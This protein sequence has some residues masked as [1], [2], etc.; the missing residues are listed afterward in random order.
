MMIYDIADLG[1]DDDEVGSRQDHSSRNA[2]TKV[3]TSSFQA[4][5]VDV[6]VGKVGRQ[7]RQRSSFRGSGA[8]AGGTFI[9]SLGRP[10]GGTRNGFEVNAVR[11]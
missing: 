11:A 8:S 2:L 5:G 3:S 7:H 10:F 6:R 1:G 9:A 4:E